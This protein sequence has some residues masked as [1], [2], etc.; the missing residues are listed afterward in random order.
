VFFEFER[1][2]MMETVSAIIPT[3]KGSSRLK[4]AI[5]SLLNQTYPLTEIIVVDDNDPQTEER[6][7]TEAIMQD[8]KEITNIIYIQHERNLNGAAA[9]NTGIKRA[10]G[11][12]LCFLDD[13]DYYFRDRI[14][15]S[16][17][18]LNKFPDKIGVYAGVDV[19]NANEKIILKI[20]PQSD[21]HIADLLQEEMI[22]GTGS[23]I[24]IY[25]SVAKKIGGF[26]EEFVRRQD[27]E[28]MIRVCHEGSVG[29][30]NKLLIVKSVNGT[31]NHPTY[32]KMKLVNNL[33]EEKFRD[34]I[35]HLDKNKNKYYEM[36]YKSLFNI[37]LSERN[38]HEIKESYQLIKSLR[39]PS[40][41]ESTL[42]F[43][44]ITG[45]RDNKLISKMFS[46]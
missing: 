21:L 7:K 5:D 46:N 17:M 24:F 9:R 36:Q 16:V 40:L 32:K 10:T 4:R 14:L 23:N 1:K 2:T 19:V 6:K 20:R 22:I 33:F 13:D 42:Y 15:E 11:K 30:L 29:Y 44:Y 37:A 43:V 38:K 3:Y 31:F 35:E 41:K 26:D 28:F 34:D 45:V 8:Y 18:Y 12:Y 25:T 39:N 27:T